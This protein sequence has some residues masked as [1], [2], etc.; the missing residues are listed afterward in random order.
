[1]RGTLIVKHRVVVTQIVKRCLGWATNGNM[2]AS[3]AYVHTPCCVYTHH[4]PTMKNHTVCTYLV[5]GGGARCPHGGPMQTRLRSHQGGHLPAGFTCTTTICG[6]TTC[7]GATTTTTTTTA[8]TTS[9]GDGPGSLPA[10]PHATRSGW[11]AIPWVWC[12]VRRSSAPAAA[13]TNWVRG[14]GGGGGRGCRTR[15]RRRPRRVAGQLAAR[16]ASGA[17]GASGGRPG[18]GAATTPR[19]VLRRQMRATTLLPAAAATAALACA[20]HTCRCRRHRYLCL[21][22]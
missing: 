2:H 12:V 3:E 14:G 1:M 7:W 15:R 9:G 16:G 13:T 11:A 5:S 4:H 6:T 18:P 20:T 22:W 17:S 8:T 19:A 10:R 21:H